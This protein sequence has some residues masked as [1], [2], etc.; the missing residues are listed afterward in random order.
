M[1]SVDDRIVR[2]E[3]DNA[4]FER[5]IDATIASLAKLDKSLKFDGAKQGL[6]EVSSIVDKFSLGKMGTVIEGVSSKFLALG[7]I[8]VTILAQITS[9]ALSTGVQLA[10]SLSLD[11]IISGFRE[12]EQNMNSIQTIL[13]NTKADGTNLGQV[14]D[15][16]AE[17]NEYADKTIYNFGQMTKNIGTFT[18]AGVDLDTSV[19]AIKGISNL[20]AISGS[21]ADQAASAMYQLSQAVS[22]GTLRLMD[23]NSVVNA[24][25]GGEV[26]QKAL[27]ETGKAMHTIKDVPMSQTFEEW[28][29]AGNSFRGSLEDEWLTAEVLTTTLQGFTG[30]M[31]EAQ[32]TAIGYTK[33]QAAE[34]LELGKTGV[35]AATKVRT[36]TGLIQTTKEAI[37]SGWS[38][39]FKIVFGNFEEA[40]ALF[41]GISGSISEM[42]S[43]SADARNE[44]LKGWKDLGGRTLLIESL[45]ET[46]KNLGAILAPIKEAFRDIFP[47]LTAKRLFELT[48]RFSDFAKALKPSGQTIDNIKRIFKGFFS[49]LEIGWTVL[50][51]GVKFIK[52]FVL[53]LT[54]LGGG[55]FLD[56]VA[57]IGDF[58]TD[59]N[60]KLVAG[61]GIKAFFSDLTG[62][63]KVAADYLVDIKDK[64]IGF[65]KGIDTPALD[66]ATEAFGRLGDRFSG[67][68]DRFA[69]AAEFFQPLK[70]ALDKVVGWLAEAWDAIRDWFAELGQKIAAVMGE[71]DFDA[72]VDAI[73][74]ALLGGIAALLAKFIKDGFSFD[75]GSGFLDKIGKSF[76]KLTGVLTAMQTNIKA[77]A[78]LKIAGAIAILTASVLV[79]SLIDSAALTKALAAMAVGFGQLMATFAIL[80]KLSAG[81]MGATS[82]VLLSTGLIMLSSALVILS[83]A[84]AI[85]ANLSWEELGRGLGGVTI[86]LGIMTAAVV[87]LS[88]NAK[89]MLLVGA[90]M[91]AIAT[92][93]SVLAGAVAI[94][95]TMSWGD[96]AKGFAAVAAGL[97]IIAGAMQL[98]PIS[99]VL[100]G[101]ALLAIAVALNILAAS[102]L[103]FATM[104]WGDLAKGMAGIAGGLLIIAGAMHLMPATLPIT[105]VGLLLVSVSLI[106]MAAALKIMGSMSWAE[107]GRGLTVMAGALLIL[108]VATNAMTGA[109]VGA[110]A[111]TVVTAAL[112]GLAVVLKIFASLS[113][114][115]LIQGLVGIAAVLAVLAVAALLIQPILPA[116]LGLGAALLVIG[117]G[118]ALFGAG[119]Y[120]VARAFQ[121]LAEA[122]EE[123][124]ASLIA[125]LKALGGAL[126]ALISGW[127]EG[128]LELIG[129][130]AKAAP[131]FAKA[132]IVLLGH[133][134]D[135]LV[136]LIPKAKEV[137]S[138]LISALIELV[139]EKYPE[140]V[141]AGI[142]LILALLQGIRDRIDDVI[143]VVSEIIREFLDALTEEIPKIAQSVADLI[144]TMWLTV[145]ETVG[146]VAGTLLFGVGMAFLKGFMDGVLGAESG[147]MKWFK[148]LGGKILGWIGN[149]LR[150]LWTKGSDFI[151]GLFSGITSKATEVISWFT[152][153]ASKVISWVGNVARTLFDKG[154]GLILGLWEGIRAQWTN[155]TNWIGDIGQKIKDAIGN[156]GTWL[157]DAGKKIIEGLLNGLK[158]GWGAVTSWVGDRM[159][160]LKNAVTHPWDLLSPS[161]VAAYYGE[162]IMVGFRQGL[163]D[164]WSSVDRFLGNLDPVSSL[165]PNLGNNMTN[166]VT[167]AITDM[168][169]QIEA[170]PDLS[171]TITP[172]LDLTRVAQDAKKL[173]TYIQPNKLTPM[174]SYNQAHSIAATTFA[175]SDAIKAPAGAGEVKFEQNIYAPTQLSTSDIYKNTRNQITMAKQELSI[176]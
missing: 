64:I 124:A 5:K 140:L 32:L 53:E 55:A 159:E 152:S 112:M 138:T 96:M 93:I 122:G 155:V 80:S 7:T 139:K 16:L 44:L 88:K 59:L 131:V 48:Q 94:F 164:E 42:V 144:T 141:L 153:L 14:N 154:W 72:A 85:L 176:P 175:E 109:I 8:A 121:I 6:S 25:M 30:E 22:T 105:A 81:P 54:G 120:L 147:P 58:F 110:I 21:S 74:V 65:F 158:N 3:F 128:L 102:L 127:Y 76:E 60:A 61:G 82:F 174:Y 101:P 15:A 104:S 111:L 20:A 46:I 79:L 56:F 137:I 12:Y 166:V 23:W 167:N 34:I 161:R 90:G 125:T 157:L 50:K 136:E 129:I 28:T 103:I 2:M 27:F 67:L 18:A 86:L 19:S 1:A 75:I 47:P 98:M 142:D 119:A 113:W 168:L 126:P 173:S 24:G 26:F 66:T 62:Y 107:I 116:M 84:V 29:K 117:A 45:K 100:T 162:M 35:E 68:K 108:A 77:N 160:D 156:A 115:E 150:T 145:A 4:A 17:L 10:K 51:E 13:A 132:L 11:Q 146:R 33:E 52:D 41:S 91:L 134:L 172:V 9:K 87:I 171:P 40:T 89:G 118:F 57:N 163:E 165:D 133:I 99:M 97:L 169:A 123:G 135:G 69:K 106:A 49:I 151:S 70:D 95:A 43:K 31:T 78:L 71:G 130:F 92:A 83:G 149:V 114:S 148:D 36:L 39:S 73:N 63:I 170:M 143:T 38:E 37:G